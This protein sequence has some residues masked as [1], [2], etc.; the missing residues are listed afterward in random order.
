M[1]GGKMKNEDRIT[2][3][4]IVYH[5]DAYELAKEVKNNLEDGWEPLGGVAVLVW[6]EVT[7]EIPDKGTVTRKP[8]PT[9]VQALIRRGVTAD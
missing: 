5:D 8:M 3:Y 1:R 9:F 2:D 4:T 6:P 7:N